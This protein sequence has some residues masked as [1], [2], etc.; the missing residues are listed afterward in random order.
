MSP[1]NTT[2]PLAFARNVEHLPLGI[3]HTYLRIKD[4]CPLSNQDHFCESG[5]LSSV[6]LVPET[7][8]IH[9]YRF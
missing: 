8:P 3:V 7:H 1:P 9:H 5:L 6:I 2:L 4:Y